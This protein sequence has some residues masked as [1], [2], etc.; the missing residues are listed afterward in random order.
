MKN[1]MGIVAVDSSS[2]VGALLRLSWPI[3]LSLMV[4]GLYNLVDSMYLAR[5]GEKVMS[6][7][8]LCFVVQNMSTF[9]FTGMATGMNARLSKALGE[10]D[11]SAAKR[12]VFN[13]IVVQAAITALFFVFGCF[14]TRSYFTLST[15]EEAVIE[16][17]VA[18]LQ[19]CMILGI[20]AAAQIFFERA[21]QGC[22]LSKYSLYCQMV[23]FGLN[24]LLD[25]ILIFGWGSIPAM[26]V[27]GAAYATILGQGSAAIMALYFNIKKNSVVF[28]QLLHENRYTKREVGRIFYIGIAASAV[29]I[30]TSIGNYCLN[31]I[32]LGFST[33][34]NAAFGIHCKIESL[35]LI[36]RQGLNVGLITLFSYY[37]GKLQ[38]HRIKKTF[39]CGLVCIGA[40]SILCTVFLLGF[41][42]LLYAPYALSDEMLEIGIPAMRIIGLTQIP[43]GCMTVLCAFFQATEHSIYTIA[44]ALIRQLIVRIPTAFLLAKLGQIAL[45]WWCWPISEVLSDLANVVFFIFAWISLMRELNL[46]VMTCSTKELLHEAE[47]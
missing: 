2:E 4:Q 40:W 12:A 34:A 8:S 31:R 21:L 26:G 25:P 39:R 1:D 27:R 19:P 20:T 33:T 5:L 43:S 44:Y 46:P 15:Q 32:L 13:G 23:G 47:L 29:G 37:R 36:P 38:I 16:N 10:A 28:S 42:K 18:Y 11:L 45:L 30:V 6:A 9:L 3:I 41:P 22:G 24:L 14:F 35:M 7:M 17:G